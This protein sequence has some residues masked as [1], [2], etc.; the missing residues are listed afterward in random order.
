MNFQKLKLQ[1]NYQKFCLFLE[2]KLLLHHY[3]L[4]TDVTESKKNYDSKSFQKYR[5]ELLFQ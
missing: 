1:C 2:R 5:N 3:Y 4:K